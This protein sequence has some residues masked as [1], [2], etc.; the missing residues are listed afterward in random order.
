MYYNFTATSDFINSLTPL[1]GGESLRFDKL[2]NNNKS[3]A[4]V[5]RGGGGT[6]KSRAVKI[7][8]INHPFALTYKH[9][10]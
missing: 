6:M 1:V 2:E 4:R 7:R 5:G 3:W 8:K 10:S 9:H